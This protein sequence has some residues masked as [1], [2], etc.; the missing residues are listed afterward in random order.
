MRPFGGPA[1]HER[2]R[3]LAALRPCEPLPADDEAWLAAHLDGCPACREIAEAFGAQGAALRGLAIPEPPRDLWARTSAGIEV[4]DGTAPWSA[5]RRRSERPPGRSPSPA[6]AGALAA[7]AVVAV[8]V[9]SSLLA[10]FSFVPAVVPAAPTPAGSA[11]ASLPGATPIPVA[12]GNVAWVSKGQDGRYNLN[13]AA[14][15]QVCPATAQAACAPLNVASQQVL[16][17]DSAPSAVMLSP[18]KSQAVVLGGGTGGKAGAVY[19]VNLAGGTASPSP[20]PSGS[21]GASSGASP[22][23][24]GASPGT[25]VSPSPSSSQVV[26]SA[27]PSPATSTPTAGASGT[28]GAGPTATPAAAEPILQGVALVGSAAYSPDGLWF[29]FAAQPA[30]GSSGPD[31]YVWRV[32]DTRARPVTADH[33]S[34]FSS[35]DG[36][37]IVGSSAAAAPPAVNPEASAS[38]SPSPDVNP[39]ASSTPAASGA[40]APTGSPA[41]SPGPTAQPYP[42]LPAAPASAQ[43][44]AGDSAVPRSFL[45]DPATGAQQQLLAPVWRPVPDPSGTYVVYWSGTLRYDALAGWV[46]DQGALYLG[47]WAALVGPTS[48]LPTASD[49]G[50]GAPSGAPSAGASTVGS[51]VAGAS[52]APSLEASATPSASV[53]VTPVAPSAPELL[54]PRSG[55]GPVTDWDL[56]WDASGRHVAVWI[57]DLTDPTIGRLSLLTVDPATGLLDP[58]RQLLTDTPALTGFSVGQDHLAWVTPAGQNGEASHLQV[59]AWQGDNAGKIQSQPAAGGSVL[60]VR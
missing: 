8:V 19:V 53:S 6:L 57:A 39:A 42:S 59:L 27:S 31:I 47:S 32:G 4:A 48:S 35:W 49:D 45:L 26:A 10:G 38:A 17:L 23:T 29:A 36:D 22:A 41:V 11:P 51:P 9:G 15:D 54:E 7:V 52:A 56:H 40:P 30:D 37:L 1:V 14:V 60:V 33:A 50:A 3:E 28:P 58:S 55:T 24:S 34:I 46:P 2:A 20:T 18:V 16:A 44:S 12:G 5:G 13:L 43:P 25:S 21:P